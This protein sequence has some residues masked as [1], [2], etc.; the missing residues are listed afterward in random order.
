M[1][2]LREHLGALSLRG[3]PRLQ[4]SG[5]QRARGDRPPLASEPRR[6]FQVANYDSRAQ[7]PP[8]YKLVTSTDAAQDRPA[9]AGRAAL[10][11]RWRCSTRW[12]RAAGGC[13]EGPVKR[14]GELR[15]QRDDGWRVAQELTEEVHGAAAALPAGAPDRHQHGLGLG[16]HPAPAA[17]PDLAE[18]DPRSGS[19]T[20]HARWRR[21]GP[22]AAGT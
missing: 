14:V 2:F 7:P 19:P 13:G 15:R 16:S 10:G 9:P 5:A 12:S 18:D 4:I 11:R 8:D 6:N 1:A 3:P 21:P 22:A 17:T 20:P